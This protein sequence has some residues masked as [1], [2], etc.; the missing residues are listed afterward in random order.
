MK[1]A[2]ATLGPAALILGL[3]GC[4]ASLSADANVNGSGEASAEA[5]SG[6]EVRDF[7][8]PMQASAATEAAAP[9]HLESSRVLLGARHDLKLDAGAATAHCQCLGVAL[10]GSQAKGM[11]WSQGAPAIDD[12]TQLALALS[13]EGVEC[14][15]EPKGSLG[16]SYWGYRIVGNDVVVLVESARGGHPLTSG[17][18]IPKPVGT[19]QVYVRP[20][21]KKLPYG[22]PLVGKGA[23]KIGNPGTARNAGFTELELGDDAPTVKAKRQS[24]ADVAGN[25]SDA[26]LT[27]EASAAA[28]K[29]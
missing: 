11:R 1:R 21:S 29:P 20:A 19:G 8:K 22:R 18:V 14:K 27:S 2:A 9:D 16:A 13:S 3:L 15:A 17:A 25:G 24:E 26:A 12:A 4:Q 7:D 5:S 6:G 28:Q 23:C 10:G